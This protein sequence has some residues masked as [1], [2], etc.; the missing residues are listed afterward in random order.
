MYDWNANTA[1]QPHAG[2]EDAPSVQ[3]RAFGRGPTKVAVVDETLRDG[4]QS[5]AGYQ[6][7]ASHKI[8]LVYAMDAIGVDVVSVGLPAAGKQNAEDCYLI[9]R[10][11]VRSKLRLIPTAAART[12]VADVQGIARAADRAGI[13]IEVY[14]FIGSSPIRLFVE[15]WDLNFLIGA[16]T[17]AAKEAVNAGLPFCLVTEDTTK[18][19]PVTVK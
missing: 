6:P 5:A 17:G 11:I 1:P 15:G 8:D 13:P 7:D 19:V 18:D 3:L 4:L 2:E 12:V 10:E 9:C 16:I 14:S